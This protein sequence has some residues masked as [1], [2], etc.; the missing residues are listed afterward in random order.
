MQSIVLAKSPLLQKT[1]KNSRISN[2]SKTKLRNAEEQSKNPSRTKNRYAGEIARG[3]NCFSLES[4][5][6]GS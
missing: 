1:Q 4:L 2:P 3:Q 6:H 5:Y